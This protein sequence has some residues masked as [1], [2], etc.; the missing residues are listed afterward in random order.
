MFISFEGVEGSGKSTQAR[1]LYER[2][3][4]RLE[5]VVL[6]HEPGGTPLGEKIMELLK[7]AGGIQIAPL[8]ELALFNASRSQLVSTVVRPH[9]EAGGTVICDRYAESSLAYQGYGRGLDLDM[10]RQAVDVA[11][12]GLRPDLIVLVDVPVREGLR[13]KRDEK[14]DR[15]ER[16]DVAFHERVREGYLRMAAAESL[17]WFVV[18]GTQSV[19]RIHELIRERVSKAIS[20]VGE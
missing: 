19:A 16:E 12:G 8:A 9:L 14:P 10:V 3:A 13:R 18:D 11:T 4:S 15:F 20:G 6:T 5:Q 2:L 1:L 17:R 7:W